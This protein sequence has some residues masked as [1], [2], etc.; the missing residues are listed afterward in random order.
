MIELNKINKVLIYK[1][2]FFENIDERR[3]IS[4]VVGNFGK[5][6]EIK[7]IKIIEFDN[8]AVKNKKIIGNHSHYHDS[9]Q[10]E[11]IIILGNENVSQV[12][13]RF[14]NYAEKRIR[15]KNLKGGGVAVVPPGCSLAL[16]P[17][18]PYVKVIEISNMEYDLNN[19]IKDEL[20]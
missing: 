13:F 5:I 6:L 7:Q 19:Y 20:F 17:L 9:N 3:K 8:K 11:V 15:K 1:N 4:G 18:N 2:N 12:D 14:R 10:W 16:M